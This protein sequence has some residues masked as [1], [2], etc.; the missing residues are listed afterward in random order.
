MTS[1]QEQFSGTGEVRAGLG[2]DEARLAAWMA[3]NVADFAGPLSVRQFNGGQ[4]NPTYKLTTPRQN[5]VLRR[6]PPG[7]LLKSAHA[8]DREY[9]VITALH[10]AGFPAPRTF[11]LC[12]DDSVIGTWFYVMDCVDGRVIW[13]TTFPDVPKPDRAAYFDAMNATIAQLHS[14]DPAAIGLGDFGKPGNYFARQITR[15]SQQYLDDTDAGRFPDM[16]KLVEWL[17]A[18]IPPGEEISVVHGDYRCDNM[19][20]HP[21]EPRVLAVLDWEL[22]TL[23]HPLADFSYHLMMYR[24]PTTTSAGLLGLDL[25]ALGIPT[26]AEY[27][28]A[29]CRRTGRDGIANM[30]FYVAYNMFRLAAIVHGIRGRVVRG[31]AASAHAKAMGETVGPLAALAWAQAQAAG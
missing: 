10:A 7:V 29:Y 30:D 28:A 23:G 5:Y 1:R 3:A 4:S 11:G 20:F 31:T 9:R 22:S 12:T 27:T 8:V 16:D 25:A 24:M 15:W 14:L 26:E 13:D 2:F 6:K 18:N 21:T 19:I 17:P